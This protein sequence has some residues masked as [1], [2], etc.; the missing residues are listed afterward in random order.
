M[1]RRWGLMLVPFALVVL[2]LITIL[3]GLFDRPPYDRSNQLDPKD[4]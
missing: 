2:F 4:G 1:K 3:I